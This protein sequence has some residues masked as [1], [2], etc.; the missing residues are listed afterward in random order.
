MWIERTR[1]SVK[2]SVVVFSASDDRHEGG[3]TD[4][5]GEDKID[6]RV[7][8]ESNSYDLRG[9]PADVLFNGAD[10]DLTEDLTHCV[11]CEASGLIVL[12]TRLGEVQ[13][14]RL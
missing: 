11:F 2:R 1:G 13:V 9:K 3:G 7:V 14:L 6:G 12:G 8:Y 5:D 4:L 10:P